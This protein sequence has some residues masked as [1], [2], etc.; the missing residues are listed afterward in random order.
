MQTATQLRDTLINFVTGLGTQKDPRSSSRFVFREIN[1]HELESR[2]R[3]DWLARRIVD[4]PAQDATR[5]WRQWAASR[6]QLEKIDSLEKV[7][8]V[9]KKMQQALIRARLYGGGALVMGVDQG[10]PEEELD[11]D[12]IGL[13][14]LK[15]L[16]CAT[17]T[18]LRLVRASTT[19]TA[20][21]TPDQSITRSRRRC[22][23]SSAS[24]A[25]PSPR[26]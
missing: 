14:D 20:P 25:E 7:L 1:R 18:S 16:S 4:L 23:G 21:I 12:D 17:A 24:K 10:Q 26:S 2:Y 8:K 9:Q 6:P 15:F 19:S 11:L 13:G 22:S 5:E 3:S